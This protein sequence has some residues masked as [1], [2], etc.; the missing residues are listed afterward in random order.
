MTVSD[1]MTPLLA[2][3]PE[4]D[5]GGEDEKEVVDMVRGNYLIALCKG[6]REI[7]R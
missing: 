6:F 2:A 1:K 3:L 4:V 7:K 5:V